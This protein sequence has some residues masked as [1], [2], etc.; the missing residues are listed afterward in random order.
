MYHHNPSALRRK[1]P[2]GRVSQRTGIQS[3]RLAPEDR[4]PFDAQNALFVI[5]AFREKQR[6]PPGGAI[7]RARDDRAT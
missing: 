3:A 4:P 7:G 6:T 2:T 5:G 1:F